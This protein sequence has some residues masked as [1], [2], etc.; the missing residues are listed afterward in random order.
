MLIPSRIIGGDK[1]YR[2]LPRAFFRKTR[3]SSKQD[4]H[5][6]I[7]KNF[8]RELQKLDMLYNTAS[9]NYTNGTSN[10]MTIKDMSQE[11]SLIH[12]EHTYFSALLSEYG[13]PQNLQVV[14]NHKYTEEGKGWRTFI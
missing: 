4:H 2:I 6:E 1:T 14:W 9:I 7:D 5:E 13:E 3:K 8:I 12:Q 11:K 10:A